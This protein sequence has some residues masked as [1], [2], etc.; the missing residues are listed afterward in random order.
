MWVCESISPGRTVACE[1]SIT[2]A[3]AGTCIEDALPT[4][5]IRC[6][7]TTITW[8]RFGWFASGSMSVP[9][10]ITV[11]T[12]GLADVELD[13]ADNCRVNKAI[14]ATNHSFIGSHLSWFCI[15]SVRIGYLTDFFASK[16]QDVTTRQV[17]KQGSEAVG[18]FPLLMG[19]S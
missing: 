15:A 19:S 14:S 8:S 10:R 16:V 2:F 13:C 6:P 4:L 18:I 5:A 17:R 11:T 1:R 3:P 7:R 12:P 9:A